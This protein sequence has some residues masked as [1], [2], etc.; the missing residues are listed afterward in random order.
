VTIRMSQFTD[1]L[2]ALGSE[3]SKLDAP[4]SSPIS[5]LYDGSDEETSS[6]QPES[7]EKRIPT[8]EYLFQRFDGRLD[9]DGQLVLGCDEQELSI[10]VTTQESFDQGRSCSDDGERAATGLVG[11]GFHKDVAYVSDIYPHDHQSL[12]NI[13]VRDAWEKQSSLLPRSGIRRFRKSIPCLGSF[14][15]S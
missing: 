10:D 12:T 4:A 13:L 14:R 2:F 1:S 5:E 15:W 6:P 8:V 11:Y 3:I 7:V 9:K